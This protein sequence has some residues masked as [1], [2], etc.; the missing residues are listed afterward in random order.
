M[1]VA[2]EGPRDI[3]LAV[4]AIGTEYCRAAATSST[5]WLRVRQRLTLW[6]AVRGQGTHAASLG[7][8][9]SRGREEA[10]EIFALAT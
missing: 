10:V 8:V 1:R 2:S 3:S 6:S 9:P 7:K 4:V 5:P